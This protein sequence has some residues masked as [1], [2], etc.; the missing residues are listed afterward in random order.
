MNPAVSIIIPVYN[1]SGYLN[2]CLDS[3]LTQSIDDIELICVN[4][5]S[6]DN[7]LDI[8]FEYASKNPERITVINN[9]SNIGGG[10]SREKALKT[11]RGTY[12]TFLDS[13]DYLAPDFIET[14]LRV[15]QNENV[16]VVIGGFVK[17]YGDRIIKIPAPRGPWSLTTYS[18][19]CAKMYRK[20]FLL[21]NDIQYSPIKCGEDIYFG[22]DLFYH[23]A[24]YRTIDY[25]GYYYYFNESST[26]NSMTANQGMERNVSSIFSHFI[27][28]HN[29]EALSEA[30]RDV[31][32]YTYLANMINALLVYDRGCGLRSMREKVDFF[33]SDLATL[34]PNFKNNR[35]V[36]LTKP[37][38]QSA[39]IRLAV[40]IV[41]RL[42]KVHLDRPLYYFVSLL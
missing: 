2:R 3:A 21:E 22:L 19:S 40:G 36:G 29:L 32:E 24:S 34:F 28:N 11:A 5:K 38:G 6:T 39:K 13:D 25:N 17:D 7:S 37:C 27:S 14:Y 8:L 42:H 35:F 4:D 16:D 31:I 12:I 23:G 26:T 1:A 9:S 15:I 20:D 30:D 10:R 18:I 33:F 41:L